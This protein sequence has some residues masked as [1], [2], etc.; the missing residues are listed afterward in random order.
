MHLIV[1]MKKKKKRFPNFI[2][3][4]IL[5]ARLRYGFLNYRGSLE[6]PLGS[7]NAFKGNFNRITRLREFHGWKMP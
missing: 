1:L 6:G 7:S 4:S 2:F 5:G 3:L